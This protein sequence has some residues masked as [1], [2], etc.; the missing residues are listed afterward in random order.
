MSGKL[1]SVLAAFAILSSLAIALTFGPSSFS[2]SGDNRTLPEK[3]DF[4]AAF[5][6]V[7][8]AFIQHPEILNP[9]I[10]AADRES[11]RLA[12]LQRMNF[13]PTSEYVSE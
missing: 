1:I 11:L 2:T 9:A 6:A 13:E 7:E 5:A 8:S 4:N 12:V 3:A 10:T